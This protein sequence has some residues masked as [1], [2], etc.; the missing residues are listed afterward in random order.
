MRRFK[1][2]NEKM[3]YL[4]SAVNPVGIVDINGDVCIFTNAPTGYLEVILRLWSKFP[5]GYI[6]LVLFACEEIGL[7][8]FQA[9]R[10]IGR[11]QY[12]KVDWC[13]DHRTRNG[14]LRAVFHQL[15]KVHG[16]RFS[17]N[18]FNAALY[19]FDSYL[20]EIN[21]EGRTINGELLSYTKWKPNQKHP[22]GELET[23]TH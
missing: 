17:E 5:K 11:L 13:G 1:N 22:L 7:K 23:T 15:L 3:E 4:L 19:K 20:K 9:E 12:A 16:V 10:T 8:H 21:F 6:D 2:M 18:A 14:I